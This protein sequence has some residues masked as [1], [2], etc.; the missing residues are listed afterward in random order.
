MVPWENCL[1]SSGLSVLIFEIRVITMPISRG[2]RVTAYNIQCSQCSL[3]SLKMSDR[4]LQS[5]SE[6]AQSQVSH[7]MVEGGD[8]SLVACEDISRLQVY[9]CVS[10]VGRGSPPDSIDYVLNRSISQN[11]TVRHSDTNHCLV[12]LS[13]T[14]VSKTRPLVCGCIQRVETAIQ[15]KNT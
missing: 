15:H 9:V 12:F 8:R 14:V 4:S 2:N 13:A 1:I 7:N 10:E 3:A 6:V 5:H 11:S